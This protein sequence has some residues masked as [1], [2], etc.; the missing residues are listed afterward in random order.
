MIIMLILGLFFIFTLVCL[1]MVFILFGKLIFNALGSI[2]GSNESRIAGRAKTLIGG[3]GE[4]L[5]NPE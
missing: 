4:I 3:L 5:Y 2:D 1:G